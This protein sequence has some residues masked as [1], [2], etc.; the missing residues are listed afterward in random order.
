M[1]TFSI[2]R[3][4]L[5][6][7]S[8]TIIGILRLR[9]FV[10][11]VHKSTV[12]WARLKYPTE[13]KVILEVLNFKKLKSRK[14][15]LFVLV[16]RRSN[17]LPWKSYISAIS[18]M[19]F[20]TVLIVN[21]QSMSSHEEFKNTGVNSVVFRSN[22]G[23]DFGAWKAG[24]RYL[25]EQSEGVLNYD[26]IIFANDSCYFPI[27]STLNFEKWM[28]TPFEFGSPLANFEVGETPHLQSFFFVAKGLK[29]INVLAEFFNNYK[30]LSSR[31]WAIEMGEKKLSE[32]VFKENL[33]AS[34]Y[35]DFFRLR[36]RY[37]RGNLTHKQPMDIIIDEDFPFMKYDIFSR[38]IDDGDLFP[39]FNGFKSRIGFFDAADDHEKLASYVKFLIMTR[40]KPSIVAKFLS[41]YGL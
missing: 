14:L 34:T 23:Y 39:L 10:Y 7:I 24:I 20:D 17:V 6:K 2:W 40:K 16:G 28:K 26:E 41:I 18:K 8:G 36:Y 5:A 38:N 33:S 15:M 11:L 4:H 35:V 22:T 1:K 31:I 3:F 32:T 37:I 9:I 13:K 21:G 19:G 25:V 12:I 30:P 29:A 27:T